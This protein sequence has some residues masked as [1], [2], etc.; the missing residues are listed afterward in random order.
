[1]LL[2]HSVSVIGQFAL[3]AQIP[4]AKAAKAAG[5]Q[6]FVPAEYGV[7][8]AEGFTYHKK[9]VQ[10]TLKDLDLPF[11]VFY[12]GFFMESFHRVS[13]YDFA[14]GKMRVVGTGDVAQ[15]TTSMVDVARF[16]A[17]TLTTAEPSDLA[18]AKIPIEGDRVTHHEIA[19]IVARKF[20]K[21][22]TIEYVDLEETRKRYTTDPFAFFAV[23][24]ADG[25]TVSG[26]KE[27]VQAA[28][29]KFFP[30]WNPKKLEEVLEI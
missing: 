21:P 18:W 28:I 14:N 29:S 8:V 15:S 4:I 13:D 12:T 30:D 2:Y 27:D 11:T 26:P 6:L 10:D 3:E 20:G 25:R 23:L 19:A 5:V 24:I 17:H 16:V 9:V 1:M 7:Y 22:I